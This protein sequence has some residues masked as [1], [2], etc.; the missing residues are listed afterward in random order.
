MTKQDLNSA[1][2]LDRIEQA[3]LQ[4]PTNTFEIITEIWDAPILAPIQV[5][6]QVIQRQQYY[7]G[8]A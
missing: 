6:Q 1:E 2:D 5:H 3:N 8:D 7:T 4:D